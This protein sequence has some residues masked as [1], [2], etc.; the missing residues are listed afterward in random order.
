[1]STEAT[2]VKEREN[3]R[4]EIEAYKS[5]L[6]DKEPTTKAHAALKASVY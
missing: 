1:M 6:Q 2:L 3:S 5:M 4:Q